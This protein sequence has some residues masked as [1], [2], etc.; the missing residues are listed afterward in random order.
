MSTK[1]A[2]SGA[3]K[4]KTTRRLSPEKQMNALFHT[5]FIAAYNGIKQYDG[6]HFKEG[7]IVM[8]VKQYINGATEGLTDPTPTIICKP[9]AKFLS[10]IFARYE[11]AIKD[12]DTAFCKILESI[13]GP[14]IASI[15]DAD[16]D[17][18][19]F[20]LCSTLNVS[21]Q[22]GVAAIST[23]QRVIGVLAEV[24]LISWFLSGRS[25]VSIVALAAACG[26]NG[27][28]MNIAV[29]TEAILESTKKTKAKAKGDDGDGDEE[30]QQ[31][32]D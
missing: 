15:R 32:D 7:E 31:T 12:H 8:T 19:L 10:G 3:P 5:Y 29:E 14:R 9:C 26:M 27:E 11:R 1:R 2:I 25:K 23:L 13:P 20:N 17:S 18:R 21:S 24:F 22:D 16:E 30:P 6:K 28:L 4:K